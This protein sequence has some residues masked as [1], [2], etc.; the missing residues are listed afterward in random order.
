MVHCAA[1]RFPDR[2]ASDPEGARRL[3]VVATE[4]LARE[5]E[6]RG[7]VLVYLSTDYVFAGTPGQAPYA[8]DATP[9][10]PN[11]YGETKLAGERAV[12]ATAPTVGVVLRV[13]VLY[14]DVERNSE[15]SVNTLLD[16]VWNRDGKKAVEMDAWSI[17]YPTNVEDVARVLKDVAD[18]YAAAAAAQGRGQPLPK[19]LQ[20]SS[21]DRTTK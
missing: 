10:P 2:C 8:A 11:F 6:S 9:S 14:G 15:S 16:A 4:H 19:L 7:A 21:E 18:K 1:E 5:C 20:F 17:R 13:P 12:L 3:N